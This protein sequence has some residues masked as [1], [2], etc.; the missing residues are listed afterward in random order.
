[1]GWFPAIRA[2][3]ALE[4]LAHLAVALLAVAS[5][6]PA[7]RVTLL[8]DSTR[9][10]LQSLAFAAGGTLPL[11]GPTMNVGPQLGPAWIWLQA[12]ILWIWPSLTAAAIAIAA[13]AA[14]KFFFY[15][16]AGRALAGMSLGLCVAVAAAAPSVQIY[17]W[18][19]LWHLNWVEVAVAGAMLLATY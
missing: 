16:W 11:A 10:L 12:G 9:D 4:T 15:Y 13:V 6:L 3:F 7:S 5:T 18:Q 14:L 17:Q 8:P 19:V 2:R 1:M